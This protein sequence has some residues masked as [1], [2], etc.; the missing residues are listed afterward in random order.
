MPA[1]DHCVWPQLAVSWLAE[2][3]I[4]EMGVGICSSVENGKD[5]DGSRYKRDDLMQAKKAPEKGSIVKKKDDFESY[6]TGDAFEVDDQVLIAAK[7]NDQESD[8]HI[9]SYVV[10]AIAKS[11]MPCTDMKMV[12][13]HLL[14]L[15]NLDHAHLCRFVEAF[16]CDSE[17]KLIY[18]RA[19]EHS[20]FDTDSDLA[21]GQPL[22]E[23]TAQ[24]YCRQVFMALSVAH[25]QGIVHGRLNDRSLLLDPLDNKSIKICDL[26]QTWI[27]RSVRK[28]SKIDYE[29]P[30]NLWNELPSS[31][32]KNYQDNVKAY[33][34]CDMWATGVVCYRMLTGKMP[35]SAKSDVKLEDVI[36]SSTAAF[37][38]EWDAM[39]DAREVVQGLLKKSGR[40]RLT[41]E[42]VLRMPWLAVSREP[43]SKS[44]MLRV[45]KNVMQNCTESTFKKFAL[46]VMAEDMSA[47]KLEV[48]ERAFRFID[49][50]GDGTLEVVEIKA[51]LRKYMKEEE[52]AISAADDI[53]LAID[54]D[55]SGSLNFAEFVA[56]SIGPQEYTDK[57]AMWECFN[58]FDKDGNGS[59]S[60]EEIATVAKRV[61]FLAEGAQIDEVVEVIAQDIELPVDFDTFVQ[62]MLTPPGQKINTMKVGW[63]RFCNNVFKVDNHKVRHLV[64]KARDQEQQEAANNP[65][66]RSP[67]RKPSSPGGGGKRRTSSTLQE[68]E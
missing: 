27:T 52:E 31:T 14:K 64:A 53:F 44:K 26:G 18:E 17:L 32:P 8:E 58:R 68:E 49:K 41:A 59:F 47:E 56:V 55:A 37:G 42:R 34:Q 62:I 30:E 51:A 43:V 1:P 4:E 12:S 61:D 24:L 33:M 19:S 13:G 45:I 38:A 29:A 57:V 67:Y 20:L 50:N 65:L 66:M 63:D 28:G 48:V 16:D 10:R 23:E 15:S 40:I 5:K 54:R 35:F 6:V 9:D 39:P 22:A 11:S 21:D 25:K 3:G 60:K 7:V 2:L 46:R 36:K